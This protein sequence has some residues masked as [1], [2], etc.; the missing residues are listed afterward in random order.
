MYVCISCTIIT[1][2]GGINNSKDSHFERSAFF[3]TFLKVN[4]YFYF[5]PFF[6]TK[7]KKTRSIISSIFSNC[8]RSFH[9]KPVA[10][11]D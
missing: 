1:F 3:F 2:T 5:P 9:E 4:F 7:Q 8:L 11:C 10:T 6:K